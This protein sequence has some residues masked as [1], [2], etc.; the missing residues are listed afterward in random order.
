[1][2]GANLKL[3][4][5]ATDVLGASGR[6]REKMPQLAKAL[7]GVVGQHHRF[8][9]RKQLQRLSDTEDD[10]SDLD[11]EIARRL[12]PHQQLLEA[13]DTIP[14]IG[15][16]T[17]EVVLAEIGSEVDRFPTPRHL[18][19]RAGL[20]PGNNQ[21]AGKRK[22]SPT[23]KGNATLKSALVESAKSAARTKTCLGAQYRRLSRRIGANKAAVAV[24]HSIII[25]L[26]T[27]IRTKERFVDLESNYFDHQDKEAI[28]RRAVRQLER[29]G[30]QVTL[31]AA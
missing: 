11:E 3:S 23:N 26:H 12:E 19:S 5:V 27:V 8:M 30:R 4:S 31:D 24:A 14:G 17:A 10:I 20:C 28:A 18:A 22:R 13:A 7:K 9:L 6:L 29:L 1:M 25:I 15:R 21:S 16:R 2:R